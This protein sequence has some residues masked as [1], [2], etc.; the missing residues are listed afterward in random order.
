MNK[1]LYIFF[2]IIIGIIISSATVYAATI[3]NSNVVLFDN[4]KN[5]MEA[6]N[7]QDA[8]DELYNKIEGSG[9][10]NMKKVT[11]SRANNPGQS[12][13]CTTKFDLTSITDYKDLVLWKNMYPTPI[14]FYSMNSGTSGYNLSYSYN[15]QTGILSVSV[16]NTLSYDG[17]LSFS[18]MDVY[19]NST[20]INNEN[21]MSIPPSI[22]NHT[23]MAVNSNFTWKCTSISTNAGLYYWQVDLTNISQIKVTGKME[24][25]PDE[26]YGQQKIVI[27]NSVPPMSSSYTA[28]KEARIWGGDFTTT[29]DVSSYSGMYYFI[30][31]VTAS[32]GSISSVE[33]IY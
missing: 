27:N 6:T 1:N 5:N 17:T 15:R 20:K 10:I 8:V 4:S 3:I 33:L 30:I 23:N 31:D 7:V 19:Y 26:K 21:L 22:F 11:V 18:K 2:G 28:L 14:G 29:L 32:S 16:D 12:T 9:S 13:N 25:Y 24:L